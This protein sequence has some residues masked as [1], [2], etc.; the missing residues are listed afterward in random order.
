M[1]FVNCYLMVQMN[2]PIGRI[3]ENGDEHRTTVSEWSYRMPRVITCLRG[4]EEE[5]T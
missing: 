1:G 3:G 5:K 2:V 4:I